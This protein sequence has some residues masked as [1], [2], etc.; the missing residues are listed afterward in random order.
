MTKLTGLLLLTLG[1]GLA[2]APP[3]W[4]QS[5]GARGGLNLSTIAVDPAGELGEINQRPGGAVGGFITF[6]EAARLSFDVSGLLSVRRVGFGPGIS[7]TITYLE[8]PLVARYLVMRPGN[9]PVRVIGGAAPAFR[10]AA[11]ESVDGDSFSVKEAYKAVDL[12]IVVGAQAE[13]KSKWLIDVR[14][15]FGVSDV[16]EIT[17]GGEQTRQR[18]LQFLV[19]YRLR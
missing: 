11:S 15:L 5:I 4:A 1:L 6:R 18:G 19:G 10:L 16:Y 14:Y 8:A 9:V 12:A 13:W 2:S 17:A 3:A 7:D